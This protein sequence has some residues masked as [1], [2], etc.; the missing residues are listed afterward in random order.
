MAITLLAELSFDP[1]T[2]RLTYVLVNPG[3][4]ALRIRR[5]IPPEDLVLR[6]LAGGAA[7]WPIFGRARPEA[8]RLEPGAAVTASFDLIEAYLFFAAGPYQVVFDYR[9][10]RSVTTPIQ[11][12]PPEMAD[13]D[14]A[15]AKSPPVT[16]VV[17]EERIAEIESRRGPRRGR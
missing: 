5:P 12:L 16:F 4:R 10:R 2:G 3:D 13:L 15:I 1:T 11:L 8:V 6:G 7:I 17:P 14:D 9:S